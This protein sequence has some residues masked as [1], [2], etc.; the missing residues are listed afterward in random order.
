MPEAKESL[1]TLF[2]KRL[3]ELKKKANI[4]ASEMSFVVNISANYLTDII[5]GKRNPSVL[6]IESYAEFF[7]V[8]PHEL[9]MPDAPIPSRETLQQNIVQYMK[10]HGYPGTPTFKKLGPSYIVKE[11]IE[12]SEPFGP[13]E[14]AEIRDI[15]NQAK[16]TSYK[17]NDV[18]RVL[19]SLAEEGVL[20]KVD[21]GN[22]KKPAYLKAPDQRFGK[23][24]RFPTLS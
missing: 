11:F 3:G 19:D 6:V 5:N 12:D 16:G 1:N 2:G 18:S 14:A 8:P 17:T 15:C 23:D 10:A 22:A 24:T 21:T 4:S 13:L 7:G 9:L 20:Y